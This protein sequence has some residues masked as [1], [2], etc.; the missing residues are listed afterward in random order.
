MRGYLELYHAFLHDVV[1]SNANLLAAGENANE[2]RDWEIINNEA[3]VEN[4]AQVISIN[5]N[6]NVI[7]VM[8]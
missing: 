8:Y 6:R 1:I 2:D 7:I 5:Y 3:R 4:P